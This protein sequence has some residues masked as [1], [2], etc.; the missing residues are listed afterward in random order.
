MKAILYSDSVEQEEEE[1]NKGL[2]ENAFCKGC[3]CIQFSERNMR[4]GEISNV[5]TYKCGNF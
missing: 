3:T 5:Q 1:E 4:G 2:N